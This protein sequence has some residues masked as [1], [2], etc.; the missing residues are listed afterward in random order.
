MFIIA[1][2]YMKNSNKSNTFYIV[3]KVSQKIAHM[4]LGW[5]GIAVDGILLIA[6]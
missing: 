4:H 1:L 2:F 3:F 5:H 6:E